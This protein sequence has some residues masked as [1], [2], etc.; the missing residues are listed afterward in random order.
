MRRPA[1]DWLKRPP[2]RR[3]DDAAVESVVFDADGLLAGLKTLSIHISMSTISV[4]LAE[5]LA[6]RL[7]SPRGRILVGQLIQ[8]GGIVEA[9]LPCQHFER[10]VGLSRH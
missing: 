6:E 9:R 10:R 4:A 3:T 8:Q 1:N 7:E 2:R 5:R